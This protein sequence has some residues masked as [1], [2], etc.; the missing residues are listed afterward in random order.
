ML[1]P[2]QA[3]NRLSRG[4]PQDRP[5]RVA[6][7]GAGLIG[8][9]HAEL[10]HREWGCTLAAVVDPAPHAKELA[11]SFGVPWLASIEGL[12]ETPRPDGVV[13]ATPNALHVPHTLACIEAGVPVLVEKPLAGSVEDAEVLVEAS[14]STDVPVLVGHHR[15]HSPLLRRAREVVESGELGSVVAVMGSAVFYKPD[16]YFAQSPWRTQPGG[17]PVLVNMVHEVD[18]LRLLCGEID[19]VHATATNHTRKLPVEDTVAIIMRFATGALATFMLSDVASS[20]R[21]W[22]QTSGESASYPHYPNEDCY[23]IAG[24]RG[25]LSVPT[26]RLRQHRGPSSWW[27]ATEDTVVPVQRHDPLAAQLRHFCDVVARAAVPLV[28]VRDAAETLRVTEAIAHSAASGETVNRPPAASSP[29][30]SERRAE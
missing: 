20:A 5:V 21:S 16:G 7:V 3:R 15:R 8:R 29:N 2:D 23:V 4:A 28:S 19:S 14:E 25:S 12:L 26:M 1:P 10:V 27:S 9:R 6:I 24:T 13:V 18:D 30:P 22:E 11:G 17:G